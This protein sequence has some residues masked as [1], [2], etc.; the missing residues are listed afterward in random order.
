MAAISQQ[1]PNLLGGASQ[2]PDPVKLPGQV[3]DATNVLLDPTF[4]CKKRPPLKYT[5]LLSTN[6]PKAQSKWFP[7]IRDEN[8][9]YVACIYRGPNSSTTYKVTV[10]SNKFRID[11][12]G[13]DNL[14]LALRENS[15]YIFDQSDSTNA[16]KPLRIS[17]TADGTHGS[18]GA[19]YTTNVTTYGTPGTTGAFTKITVA[20]SAPVLYYYDTSTAAAGGQLDTAAYT[21]DATNIRVWNAKT[22]HEQKVTYQPGVAEYLWDSANQ[23]IDS[24][25]PLTVNDYTFLCNTEKT[26]SMSTATSGAAVQQALVVIN[27][28]AYNTTY[29]VDFLKDGT[30]T[31]Q[32]KVYHASKLSVSPGT[33]EVTGDEGGCSQAGSASFT[34]TSGS[35]TAL[36]FT[37]TTACTPTLVSTPVEGT[38]Y[39]QTHG[40]HWVGHENQTYTYHMQAFATKSLGKSA[41]YYPPGSQ[42]VYHDF[43]NCAVAG[44]GTVNLRIYWAVEKNPNINGHN[45]F[46]NPRAEI[47]GGSGGYTTTGTWREGQKVYLTETLST[48]VERYPE[49]DY[50]YQDVNKTYNDPETSH[51]DAIDHSSLHPGIAHSQWESGAT[52]GMDFELKNVSV[53]DNPDDTSYKSKYRT[54]VTLTNGGQG[55]RKGDS[56]TVTHFGRSYTITVE[57]ERHTFTYASDTSV[58]YTT[59]ANATSGQLDV[60]TIASS[61]TSAISA[62]SNYSA[63]AVG[64]VIHILRTDTGH[65]FNIMTRGGTADQ[66]LY[67]IKGSVD[68]ITMLPTQCVG[69]TQANPEG[70]VLKVRNTAESDDDDY[71]VKFVPS[72]GN[73]PGH[74]SWEETVKPETAT[75]LNAS[76]MPHALIRLADGTFNVRPLSQSEATDDLPAFWA[77]RNVG[78]TETNPDPSFIDQTITGMFFYMNRL[79]ML[80]EDAVVLSQPGDFFNFFNSSAIA[81]SDADPIDMTASATKP[82]LLKNAIG[83]AKG[84]LL[85][86][87]NSQFL[88]A[89]TEAAFGPST[90]KMTE[91]SNYAYTSVIPPVET[92]MSVM[93][94]TEADTFSKVFEMAVDSVDNRPVISENT[95]IIPEYIPPNLTLS[96]TSPNNSFVAF[97]NDTDTLYTFKFFNTGNE[98]N[99]AGWA[100][101]KMPA[102]VR[103]F[104]FAHDTGYMVLYNGTSYILSELEMLDDPDTSPIIVKENRF[105]P[106]LDNYLPDTKV[107]KVA[108]ASLTKLYF[109]EGAYVTGKSPNVTFTSTLSSTLFLRPSIKSDATGYYVEVNNDVASESF[110]LGLEYELEVKLPSFHVS[111]D[112]GRSD[113]RNPPMVENVYLD[114]YLSGRYSIVLSRLGYTDATLD[115]DVQQA[116]VYL[117]ND[118]AVKDI[119]TRAI[120][121]YTRGDQV[122]ITVKSSDPLP[123]SITSY[124]WEGHYNTRGIQLLAS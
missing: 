109:P 1:I 12:S 22:G 8:E 6:I 45:K 46:S 81:I 106:R 30:S 69:P 3:K 78:D 18:G 67:G 75:E 27:Q 11:G 76:T 93:F 59:P 65:E 85:F 52:I 115:L 72:A 66:A 88:L 74:G 4:G 56:V 15:T 86:A 2:Q 104:Q 112:K 25:K 91:I 49:S 53:Q 101:W 17:T 10:V 9:H 39:P 71:Y 5:N 44:A 50:N 117:A 42:N 29:A 84:L 120:P 95:R 77:G 119:V 121:V 102:P 107:T 32:V 54:N 90:V 108:G 13:S 7:I 98:R 82:A 31:E 116:D 34:E 19:E 58:T 35:K 97:G 114:L 16:G 73:I 26:V 28:V 118:P 124:S 41:D 20:A 111:K 96:A 83:T 63:T 24:I 21:T 61:L 37:L 48:D 122:G 79:G 51:S 113:R 80:T 94:S 87:E 105:L 38:P 92:G 57:D 103:L 55:W 62:L 68:D 89:T 43:Y 123:S 60:G 70:V 36:G 110:I 33:H 23:K 100:K 14:T 64:N 99:L 40:F 47:I